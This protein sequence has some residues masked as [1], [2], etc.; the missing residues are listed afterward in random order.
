[1]S[2]SLIL[3]AAPATLCSWVIGSALDAAFLPSVVD[4]AVRPTDVGK[5][6][7]DP[8]YARKLVPSKNRWFDGI[9][10]SQLV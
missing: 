4:A 7:V 9:P 3:L 10:R 8:T 2:N 5:T 1:M 6:S